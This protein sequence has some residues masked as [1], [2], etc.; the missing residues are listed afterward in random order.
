M[1]QSLPLLVAAYAILFF[2]LALVNIRAALSPPVYDDLARSLGS[3]P[4]A[5]LRRV[6]LPLITRGWARHRARLHLGHHGVDGLVAPVAPIGTQTL[7]TRFWSHAESIAYGA[8][9]PYAALMVIISVP[10]TY[11]LT[12]QTRQAGRSLT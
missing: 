10:M 3:S 12:R 6:T 7:A 9:T 2:P 1:Y 8:A 11:F 4:L 5:V